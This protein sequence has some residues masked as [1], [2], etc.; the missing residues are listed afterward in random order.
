MDR[1]GAIASEKFL[2]SEEFYAY[3][4]TTL[5]SVRATCP[6]IFITRQEGSWNEVLASAARISISADLF[7]LDRAARTS[8]TQ[9]R[10]I[11]LDP[12]NFCGVSP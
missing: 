9:W 12:N 10:R 6:H 2:L 8:Q 11:F 4:E 1:L 7:T 5:D 3:S